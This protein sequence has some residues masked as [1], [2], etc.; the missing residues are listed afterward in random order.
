[1]ENC[2]A[3][4]FTLTVEP[5]SF[6]EISITTIL[7][8]LHIPEDTN[9]LTR[10]SGICSVMSFATLDLWLHYLN[11]NAIE[12]WK[13]P[14]SN[15]YKIDCRYTKTLIVSPST[16]IYVLPRNSFYE[17]FWLQYKTVL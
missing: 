2:T 16:I 9:L 15:V 17:V 12:E 13:K 3:T 6:C 7:L 14:I 4:V 8:W 10:Q 11:I 5:E 1:L